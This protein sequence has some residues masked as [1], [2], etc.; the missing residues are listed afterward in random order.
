MTCIE[1]SELNGRVGNRDH[2]A[3]SRQ[4]E[5]QILSCVGR[6]IQRA[7]HPNTLTGA[8]PFDFKTA[9]GGY[10]DIKIYSKPVISV[11][12]QQYRRGQQVTG[13]FMNI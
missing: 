6:L 3:K 11:E 5:Q 13:W 1:I 4:A 8:T 7:I 9:K 2:F 10:G 12:L